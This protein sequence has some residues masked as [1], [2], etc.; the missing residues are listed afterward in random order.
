MFAE[1]GVLMIW[2]PLISET[3]W[4]RDGA[5]IPALISSVLSNGFLSD[6]IVER[7]AASENG[8]LRMQIASSQRWNEK[9]ES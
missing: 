8:S 6:A 7:A 1:A 5:N 2:T 3:I 9:S 4:P